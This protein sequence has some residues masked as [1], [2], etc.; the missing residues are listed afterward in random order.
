[1]VLAGD[2]I[3]GNQLGAMAWTPW[4]GLQGPGQAGFSWGKPS[5]SSLQWDR[6]PTLSLGAARLW[7]LAQAKGVVVCGWGCG[8]SRRYVRV[9]AF[10]FVSL[11]SHMSRL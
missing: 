9:C 10:A 1:M 11:F 8:G 6:L 3:L 4:R 5:L 2:R 7:E